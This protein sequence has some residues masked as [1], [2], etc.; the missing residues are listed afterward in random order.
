M[1][2]SGHSGVLPGV[3]FTYQA[4]YRDGMSKLASIIRSVQIRTPIQG[5][6]QR[7]VEL[8]LANVKARMEA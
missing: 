8:M 2:L 3:S 4:E 5:Q 1:A 6:N 7:E